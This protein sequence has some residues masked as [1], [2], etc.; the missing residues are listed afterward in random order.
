MGTVITFP[1][2]R[3]GC[4]DSHHGGAQGESATIIILPVIRI[5]RFNDDPTDGMSEGS[6]PGRKRRRRATRS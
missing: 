4:R 5:D 6:S 2:A 3:R 1:D